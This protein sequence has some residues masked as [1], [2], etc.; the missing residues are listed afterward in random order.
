MKAAARQRSVFIHSSS[1]RHWPTRSTSTC[2][3]GADDCGSWVWPAGIGGAGDG[4]RTRTV[5][6]GIVLNRTRTGA[7]SQV[8]TQM[9]SRAGPTVDRPEPA[10]TV[11][12]GTDRARSR[13][14][15][16]AGVLAI[17]V[18]ARTTPDRGNDRYYGGESWTCGF[19]RGSWPS[20]CTAVVELVR[21]AR[22]KRLPTDRHRLP[23][24]LACRLDHRAARQPG[25]NGHK[26]I[27]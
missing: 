22:R 12:S 1:G 3:R 26:G 27:R 9:S 16:N 17:L 15:T 24:P 8:A 18:V 5:S 2:R 11:A 13:A 4:N 21:R 25:T 20:R 10:L 19:G 7:F 14:V 23:L 6:L